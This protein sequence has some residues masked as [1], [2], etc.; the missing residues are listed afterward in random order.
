MPLA[1]ALSVA[2]V[3]VEGHLVEV[4]AD[5]AQGL[6]G[7]TLIGLPDASLHEARDRVR[8]AIVNSGE[9]WPQRRITLG[10]SPASLPKRGSGFDLAMAAAILTAAGSLPVSA[11]TGLLLLGELGLDGRVRPVRGVL[12]AVL[13]ALAAG[14]ERVVVP[15][16][17]LAEARLVPGIS[18]VGVGS[19]RTLVAVLRGRPADAADDEDSEVA[20]PAGQGL[21]PAGAPSLGLDLADVVGQVHGRW[22]V[23]VAAAGGHHLYLSGP[24]GA[25]KT[26]LAERLPGLLPGLDMDAALEVTAVHSV[27]GALPASESLITRP[28]YRDPHHT[29]SV[30]ALVGGGSGLARPGE[31]SLAHAKVHRCSL[32]ARLGKRGLTGSLRPRRAAVAITAGHSEEASWLYGGRQMVVDAPDRRRQVPVCQT[33]A[34]DSAAVSRWPGS[35]RGRS[36][37]AQFD[38]S[39]RRIDRRER[40][41]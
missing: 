40:G 28:P 15:R 14:V 17:N 13:T 33:T 34:T 7:L 23:E 41:E 26:M 16:A 21:A 30:S 19:L 22:A 11:L 12:P 29:A 10:L 25:G 27:A 20:G 4:E 18:V 39:T 8:A 1:R 36:L 31:V 38:E 37:S 24:P 6:P 3:G 5:L 9:S 35:P 32:T 2:V